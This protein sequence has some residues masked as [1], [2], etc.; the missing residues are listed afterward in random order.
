[1]TFIQFAEQ[2]STSQTLQIIKSVS[3]AE[4][5]Y[6]IENETTVRVTQRQYA[7]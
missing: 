7:C 2:N 3:S 4:W 5:H 6:H 1:M